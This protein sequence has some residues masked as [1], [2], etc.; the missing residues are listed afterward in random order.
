M[1]SQAE[2]VEAVPTVNVLGVVRLSSAFIIDDVPTTT[3][4][5]VAR[6][7]NPGVAW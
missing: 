2:A 1:Y 6:V 7:P 3:I 4:G 5:M